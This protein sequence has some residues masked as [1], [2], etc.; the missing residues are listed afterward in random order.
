MSVQNFDIYLYMASRIPME[1]LD[2]LQ[3]YPATKKLINTIFMVKV[4]SLLK[5]EEI[6][7]LKCIHCDQLYTE[8]QRKVLVCPHAKPEAGRPPQLHQSDTSWNFIIFIQFLKKKYRISW[9]AVYWKVWSYIHLFKCERC[10]SYFHIH[11][12][13][14]CAI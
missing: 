4:K 8:N 13:G 11:D 6:L 12:I 14:Q 10:T 7:L 3:S 2:E 9:R 5:K 1:K